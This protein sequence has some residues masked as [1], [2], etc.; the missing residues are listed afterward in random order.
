V[1]LR[2]DGAE[3][4]FIFCVLWANSSSTGENIKALPNATPPN[5]DLLKKE[6]RE[7]SVTSILFSEVNSLAFGSFKPSFFNI[8]S[9]G[10]ILLSC[11][12][13]SRC[14]SLANSW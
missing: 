7:F 13:I 12:M 9:A 8:F 1:I 5:A 2:S 6:R 10:V 3:L 14:C 4:R 11:F